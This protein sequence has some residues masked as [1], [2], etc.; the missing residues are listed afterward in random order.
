MS[1][2][3]WG[4]DSVDKVLALQAEGAMAHLCISIIGVDGDRQVPGFHQLASL[5]KTGAPESVGDC[6]KN[7]VFWLK[8]TPEGSCT[9]AHT[10]TPNTDA[11][12]W[13]L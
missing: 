3:D 7:K 8:E 12:Q 10:H 4:D 13:R 1:F 5:D 6:L 2:S 11:C 9:H